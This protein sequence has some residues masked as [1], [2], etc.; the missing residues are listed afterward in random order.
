MTIDTI[1]R[2]SID[3]HVHIGPEIIPRK[4]IVPTLLAGQTGRIAGMALKNH[5]FSTVPFINE[6]N[7]TKLMLIGSVVLNTF[8]GGLNPDAVYA[9]STLAKETFIVWF[10]TVSSKQFLKNSPWEIAPEWVKRKN[11]MA[12]TSKEV[13]GI[14]II[15]T[16][17]KLK[18]EAI[19]V[20]K[21]IKKTGAILA[22]GH[23]SWKASLALVKAASAM[24]IKKIIVTHPIYQKIAMPVDVQKQLTRYGAIIEQ[25]Y[26]MYLIDK[27]PISTIASQIKA[28][29]YQYCV[30]SSDVGQAFSPAPSVALKR[31]S[32]LLIREGTSLEQLTTMLV[33]NPKRLIGI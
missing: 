28:V 4:F 1:I 3:L 22:T 30:I 9:A 27:I 14:D 33:K 5:F 26:S 12:R 25:C 29:G 6:I 16:N 24:G 10:P 8:V 21:V 17:G 2:R 7:K 31:F 32:R 20:L 11:F 18:N 15:D 23:I 19:R 13:D